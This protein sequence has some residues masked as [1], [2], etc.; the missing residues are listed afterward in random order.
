MCGVWRFRG[1]G[2]ECLQ[3]GGVSGGSREGIWDVQGCGVRVV[4]CLGIEGG[5]SE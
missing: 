3:G 5:V 1:L 2:V 4:G